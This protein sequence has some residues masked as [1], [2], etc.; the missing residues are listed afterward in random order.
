MFELGKTIFR[1]NGI[2]L[3]AIIFCMGLAIW[4]KFIAINL[5]HVT[6]AEF[7][8]LN[9][10]NI[11]AESRSYSLGENVFLPSM[12][13]IISCLML[14]WMG[15]T[16]LITS[17]SEETKFNFSLRLILGVSQV[18]L[19]GWFLYTGGKLALYSAVF[20]LVLLAAVAFIVSV[21]TH[22]DSRK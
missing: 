6:L 10:D 16:N 9:F 17:S 7:I 2:Q 15:I 1:I 13:Y 12:M 8:S 21:F 18:I 4:A 5:D 20:S 14:L 11:F 22:N 19:F 3:A